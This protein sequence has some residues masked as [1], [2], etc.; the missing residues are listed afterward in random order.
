MAAL[1]L[2]TG[3]SLWSFA[4]LETTAFALFVTLGLTVYLGE[5]RR[6]RAGVASAVLLF[7][8]ALVRPDGVV[9]FGVAWAWRALG[10]LRRWDRSAAVRFVAW[11]AA[12]A[13]PFAAY[14]GWRWA[15][16][17]DLFPNTYYLKTGGGSDFYGR[18]AWYAWDFFSIYWIWLGAA[19]I[20][21]IWRERGDGRQASLFGA[22]L[23]VVWFAYVVAGGGDWMPYFRFFVPV[24]PLLYVLILHGLIDVAAQ[25]GSGMN[26]RKAMHWV[27]IGAAAAIVGFSSVRPYDNATAKDPSGFQSDILP[28]AINVDVHRSIGLWF[29]DNVP[30]EFTVAQIATGIV[31]YYSEGKTLDMLGVNDRHIARSDVRVPHQPAGHDKQDGAYVLLSKPEVIWLSVGLE[32]MPRRTPADYNPPIDERIAPVITDVSHNAY[33]WVFYRPVAVRFE[34]GWLNLL[35]RTDVDVPA[36]SEAN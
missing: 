31:P 17:G 21:S 6:E 36:L 29:R 8:A 20:A 19:V 3:L 13:V 22:A 14:W 26:A 30:P 9:I 32:A 33:V 5:Q 35:V 16:Y 12:F 27:A 24:M 18:G 10:L 15:Y 28:G 2:N 25:L 7:V 34:G 23:I 11:T 4:G 1:S